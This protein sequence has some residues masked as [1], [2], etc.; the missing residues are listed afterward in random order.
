L[1]RSAIV[2]TVYRLMNLPW[3]HINEVLIYKYICYIINANANYLQKR[4]VHNR[5]LGR[6][7]KSIFL[8]VFKCK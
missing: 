5:T 4:D 6:D 3:L 8:N 7:V 2:L 1:K